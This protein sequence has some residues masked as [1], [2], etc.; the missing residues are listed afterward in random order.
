MVSIPI[1]RAAYEAIR[2]SL[3]D[4]ERAPAAEGGLIRI[5]LDRAVVDRLG[6]MRGP[7]ES[8][9]DVILRVGEGG[10]VVREAIHCSF[11]GEAQ[12]SRHARIP[13][14]CSTATSVTL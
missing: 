8:Y 12:D 7:G 11:C 13:L 14:R 6:R 9:S 2:A 3:P 4:Q 5:W 1:T 10:R